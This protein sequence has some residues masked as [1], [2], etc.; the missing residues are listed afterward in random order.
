[1]LVD[2][3]ELAGRPTG[4]G[5]YLFHILREWAREPDHPHRYSVVL[6][7]APAPELVAL[8]DRISWLHEPARSHGTRWEQ[9]RLARVAA[10][11]APDVFFAAGY[12]APLRLRCPFILAVYDVSFFAH[13]EWFGAREGLRRRF[14]TR[15]AARR[16]HSVLTISEFSARE[17][18]RYLGVPPTRIRL[19]PP[20]VS[21][22]TEVDLWK[23]PGSSEP[24]DPGVLHRSTSVPL[25]LYAG[26]LFTRRHIPELIEGFALAAARVPGARLV[27]V[28]DNRTRPPIDPP[29]IAAR[30][31]VPEGVD[32]RRYVTDAELHELY[33]AARV[34]AFLSEYEGFG[35]TPMEALAHGVPLVLLDAEVSREVYGAGAAYVSLEPAAIGEALTRLLTDDQAHAALR[36]AGRARLSHFSWSRSAGVIRRALEEAAARS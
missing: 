34:F 26:S 27:L 7:T 36:D 23:T 11:V 8:G 31:G 29:A 25:V 10:T 21:R 15:A 9:T 22:G 13:P 16:A 6:P 17:I 32:W 33:A 3:R 5:R 18:E 19:A 4:V 1:V 20:G 2:G 35:M 30:A 12:T 14:V 24:G 28:G